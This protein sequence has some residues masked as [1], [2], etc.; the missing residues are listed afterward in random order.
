MLFLCVFTWN[1]MS[2]KKIMEASGDYLPRTNSVFTKA[3]ERTKGHNPPLH[4][5]VSPAKETK[6]WNI[7]EVVWGKWFQ[8][9]PLLLKVPLEKWMSIPW[10]DMQKINCKFKRKHTVLWTAS[11][12]CPPW[13]KGS[14]P[15]PSTRTNSISTNGKQSTSFKR[16][17]TNK[18]EAW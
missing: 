11:S 8:M 17:T 12:F 18:C 9:P 5:S 15:N 14:R 4:C 10:N 7:A 3:Q 13:S 1:C 2:I 16:L 6:P